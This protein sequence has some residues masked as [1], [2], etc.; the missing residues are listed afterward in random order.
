MSYLTGIALLSLSLMM[1]GILG[2]LQERT[3]TKYGPVWREGLFY[4]V[5]DTLSPRVYLTQ[6]VSLQH[7]MSL[8]LMVST[9]GISNSL[10]AI[11]AADV[12]TMLP[13]IV[14]N[15]LTQSLCVAGVNQLMSVSLPRVVCDPPVA[16]ILQR[17]SSVSTNMVLTTRKA[18]SLCISVWYFGS[19]WNAQLGLGAGLVGIGTVL[20]AYGSQPSSPPTPAK[21]KTD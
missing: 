9:S 2:I 10:Q 7:A 21:V 15:V 12:R 16:D 3:F 8:P 4:T 19:G 17:V 14:L 11:R 1:A 5:R 20:Y 13:V 6:E 18:L